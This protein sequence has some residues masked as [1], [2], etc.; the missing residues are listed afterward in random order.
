MNFFREHS[1][2]I[3]LAG[4]LVLFFLLGAIIPHQTA[5]TEDAPG[6]IQATSYLILVIARVVAIGMLLA[7]FWRSYKDDFP[8]RVDHWGVIAGVVGGALWIVICGL[9]IESALLDLVG[10]SRDWF[11]QRSSVNPFELYDN[12]LQRN[13]F[14]GFRFTLLVLVVPVAEELFLRPFLMRMIDGDEWQTQKLSEIGMLGLASGT[15]YGVLTHPSEFVAAALWFTMVTVVMVRTGK[16]WNC[17]VT[18]MITNLILGVYLV[19][20]GSWHLW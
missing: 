16:F 13:A 5:A 9:G 18:H 2:L 8:I 11:G 15:L 19:A 1:K 14:W 4:P 10:L 12:A 3:S 17:V 20:T 7:F 6:Q